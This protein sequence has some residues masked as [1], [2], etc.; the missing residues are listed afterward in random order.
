MAVTFTVE[1]HGLNELM[2]AL[3]ETVLNLS[4]KRKLI[5]KSLREGS[6]PQLSEQERNAPDDLETSGSRIRDNLGISVTEQTA[7][8]GEARIGSK[9]WG[10]AGR[11][12]EHGTIHQPGH[13][14]MGP[15]F[16]AQVEESI[17]IIGDVLGDGIEDSFA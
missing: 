7:T 1:L 16:D 12:A 6:K 13:P 3:D 14:W 15:A 8:H 4:Q 5:A 10:F 17:R 11:F 2:M 9:K